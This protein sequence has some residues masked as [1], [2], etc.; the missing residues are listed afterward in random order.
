[1]E[2]AGAAAATGAAALTAA[3]GG[4]LPGASVGSLMVGAD[5]GFG[6]KLMRT[7]S[8]FG[9]TL[10]ASAGLG[11]NAPP[12]DGGIF[13]AIIVPSGH[14]VGFADAAVKS[15]LQCLQCLEARLQLAAFIL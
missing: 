14:K 7:V 10:L 13:S 2:E 5:V 1:L 9:W 11:G 6:G 12:G 8:F 4:A 15:Q 3:T